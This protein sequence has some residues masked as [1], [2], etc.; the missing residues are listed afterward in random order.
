MKS[1]VKSRC[2]RYCTYKFQKIQSTQPFGLIRSKVYQEAKRS[3]DV[4]SSVPVPVPGIIQVP[5][6]VDGFKIISVPI[7]FPLTEISLA[8]RSTEV[9]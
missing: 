8:K 1:L 5:V 4:S 9:H 7:P 3:T 6:P 2:M